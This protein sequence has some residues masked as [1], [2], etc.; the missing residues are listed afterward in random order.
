MSLFTLFALL[1]LFFFYKWASVEHSDEKTS[2]VAEKLEETKK[3]MKVGCVFFSSFWV[4][5]C[6]Y[7]C[8]GQ[9]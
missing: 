2:I 6:A 9:Y 4:Y 1:N 7:H 8:P 3:V 5:A